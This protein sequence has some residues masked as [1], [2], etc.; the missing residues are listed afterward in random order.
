MITG[1]DILK[2]ILNTARVE[3]I[4]D[5]SAFQQKVLSLK[6]QKQ[7]LTAPN[8]CV[9]GIKEYTSNMFKSPYKEMFLNSFKNVNDIGNYQACID[10]GNSDYHLLTLNLT[11]LPIILHMGSCLPKECTHKDIKRSADQI[12]SFLYATIHPLTEDIEYLAKMNFTV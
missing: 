8:Q 3:V 4:E 5:K 11:Q 6:Q 10:S 1:S 9:H 12:S 7:Q 2:S